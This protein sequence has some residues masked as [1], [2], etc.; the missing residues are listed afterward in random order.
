LIEYIID[1]YTLEPGVRKLN[2]KL[3]EI[4]REIN[5][6]NLEN[7]DS[8]LITNKQLIDEILTRHYKVRHYQIHKTPQVGL[9]NGLQLVA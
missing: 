4:F 6:R 7:P 5:L 8:I 1:T 3:Y 2:E 9:V